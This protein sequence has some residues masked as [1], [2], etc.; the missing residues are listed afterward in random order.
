MYT[1]PS[2]VSFLGNQPIQGRRNSLIRGVSPDDDSEALTNKDHNDNEK[3]PDNKTESR[4]SS[5][6]IIDEHLKVDS[7]V[8]EGYYEDVDKKRD[9]Q[10]RDIV[11]VL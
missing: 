8:Q 5:T 6:S 1:L 11:N 9:I 2:V 3:C 4:T 7:Y 10:V